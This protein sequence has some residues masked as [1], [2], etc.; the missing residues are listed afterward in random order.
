[1]VVDVS[2]CTAA[3]TF[4][5][6]RS[7]AAAMASIGTTSPQGASTVSIAPP[8]RSTISRSSSPNRPKLTISTVSPGAIRLTR[9]A[10]IAA[11]AVPSTRKVQWFSVPK[12]GR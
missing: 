5:P 12:I 4:G 11:R 8:I 1:M 3:T 7:I 6:V 10:S 9:A 2:P